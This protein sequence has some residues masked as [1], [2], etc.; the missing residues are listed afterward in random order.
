MSLDQF[1]LFD[2]RFD[3]FTADEI[4]KN[5]DSM[6]IEQMEILDVV[7]RNDE[8]QLQS[9]IYIDGPGGSG[10]TFLLNT[11]ISALKRNGKIVIPVSSSGIASQLI[12]GG[13]TAHSK[14]K[15]PMNHDE[16]ST[17]NISVQSNLANLIKKTNIIIWDEATMMHKDLLEAFNRSLQDIM[18]CSQLFGGISVIFSGDFRQTLPV[19]KHGNQAMIVNASIK[20]CSFWC[21]LR[22]FKLT[23]N[24]RV[25]EDNEYDQIVMDIGNGITK[26]IDYGNSSFNVVENLSELIQKVFFQTPEW[27]RN[28]AILAPHNNVVNKINKM[29]IDLFEG[30]PHTFLSMDSVQINEDNVYPTE[31]LNS[32][33]IPGF[34]SHLLEIKQGCHVMLLRNLFPKQGFCNGTRMKVLSWSRNTIYC[35]ILYGTSKGEKI[36]IPRILLLAQEDTLPFTLRRIQFPLK[37]CFAMTINKS[38]GQTLDKVG[39]CLINEIFSHGQLYVAM[40]RVRRMDDLIVFVQGENKQ[41]R[42]VVFNEILH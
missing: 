24:M 4:S 40:S 35:E 14:F 12:F 27:G 23:Q 16:F 21:E 33:E 32:I 3:C 6:N 28:R 34:P 5:V 17:C 39:L 8:L 38:Q 30:N 41:S 25:R 31:Y 11:I 7:L 10:K 9:A 1:I 37:L 13:R 15:V 42:N 18:K 22:K 2:Q 19:I 26:F 36:F 20:N 29:V